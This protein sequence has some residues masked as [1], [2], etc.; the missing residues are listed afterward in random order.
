M[1]SM[2]TAKAAA[3]SVPAIAVVSTVHVAAMV[4]ITGG[5]PFSRKVAA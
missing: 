5:R 2:P 1:I 4:T 3:V